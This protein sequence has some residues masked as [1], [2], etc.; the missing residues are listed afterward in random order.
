MCQNHTMDKKRLIIID[1]DALLYRSFHALPPL[2]TKKGEQTGA[3][4]GFLLTMFKA[5]KEFNPDF[6]VACFDFPAPTFRHKKFKAYKGKR[7]P[8]PEELSQ[9]VPKLKE[10]LKAL[11]IPIFEKERFEADDII[12]TISHEAPRKQVIPEIESIVLSGDLDVLQLVNSHTKAYILKRGIK[13]AVLYDAKK[14]QERYG[15]LLPSQLLD[16]KALKGDPSDNIP[17]VTGIGEKTAIKLIKEFGDLETLYRNL[18]GDSEKARKLPPKLKELL[19]KYKEQAFFS[20]DLAKIKKDV[21][22]K[23]DL[24]RCKWVSPFKSPEIR[25]KLERVLSKYEFY[26]LIKKL[27]GRKEPEQEK[28]IKEKTNIQETLL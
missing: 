8:M 6:I 18:E 13:D 19:L 1:S 7:P 24:R 12:G 10:I 3:I 5:V 11:G 14:V 28:T 4:Y 25:E 17:G 27:S 23:F 9:Q 2:T 21:P 22:V 16:F 15:G 26:S 20:R